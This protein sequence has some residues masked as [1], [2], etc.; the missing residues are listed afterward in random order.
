MM[1]DPA[2]NPWAWVRDAD[3]AL[4]A[5][6]D[7]PADV[8]RFVRRLRD[9]LDRLN[10]YRAEP[11]AIEDGLWIPRCKREVRRSQIQLARALER[12]SAKKVSDE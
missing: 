4:I 10:R 3:P 12:L 5:A 11:D 9:D 1:A 8:D 6:S 7:F 2:P